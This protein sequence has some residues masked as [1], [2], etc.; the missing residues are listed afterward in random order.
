MKLFH[1]Q[2]F[3]FLSSPLSIFLP[4]LYFYLSVRDQISPPF[5]SIGKI[6]LPYFNLNI[7]GNK[8]ERRQTGSNDSRLSLK[9]VCSYFLHERNVDSVKLLTN[10]LTLPHYQIMY[11]LYE[12]CDFVR[13]SVCLHIY[14]LSSLRTSL[15]TNLI[16]SDLQIFCVFLSSVYIIA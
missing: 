4:S 5:K 2:C 14:I 8:M 12:R 16:T 9:S 3:P 15:P 13:H 7:Y 10:I 6:I 11:S 1:M